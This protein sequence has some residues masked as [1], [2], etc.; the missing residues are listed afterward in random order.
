M[1]LLLEPLTVLTKPFKTC[2]NLLQEVEENNK[3]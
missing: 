2:I 1:K 3:R